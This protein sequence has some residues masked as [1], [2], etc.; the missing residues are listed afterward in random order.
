MFIFI[1]VLLMA[2]IL[3]SSAVDCGF[4][5]QPKDLQKKF[6]ASPLGIRIMCQSAGT[7]VTAAC[8]FS[9]LALLKKIGLSVLI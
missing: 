9:E 2:I 4:E 1:M 3:A 5:G 7:C 8:C 6:A